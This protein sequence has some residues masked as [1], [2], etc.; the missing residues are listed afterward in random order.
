[1]TATPQPGSANQLTALYRETIVR[2]AVNPTGYKEEIEAT[3]LGEL[4]N[5]L[6][7]DRVVVHLKIH[8]DRIEAMAFSGDSCA[9]C[10]ASASLMCAQFSGTKTAELAGAHRWLKSALEGRDEP[11][12][13]EALTPLLGVRAYPSRVK[14]ALLP[15]EAA[16]KAMTAD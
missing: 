12:A 4:Y 13:I 15:W 11:I 2:H 16:E 8:Q 7:G 10:T 3:H 6:C 14:C 5:P 9:I 1:M